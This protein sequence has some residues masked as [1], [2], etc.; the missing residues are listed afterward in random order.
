VGHVTASV[1]GTNV[2]D[3]YLVG[4]GSALTKLG[5]RYNASHRL[6]NCFFAWA[7]N[8]NLVTLANWCADVVVAA[9]S[10]NYQFEQGKPLRKAET[11]PICY[12]DLTVKLDLFSPPEVGGRGCAWNADMS[13]P[14]RGS[15]FTT[16]RNPDA[17][18]Q[19]VDQCPWGY[20]RRPNDSSV[21]F[22]NSQMDYCRY[23]DDA[24][25]WSCGHLRPQAVTW[26][27]DPKRFKT[28]DSLGDC[29]ACTP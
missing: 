25:L 11:V 8:D 15:W 18:C 20:F 6:G 1:G 14:Y 23:K 13:V 7:H 5:A 22:S 28:C 3:F 2:I 4:R 26:V 12:P 19:T 9:S 16:S 24:H 21:Y 27:W 10:T 17:V 29:P